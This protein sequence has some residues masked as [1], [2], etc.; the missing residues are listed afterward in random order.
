MSAN[1]KR[2]NNDEPIVVESVNT[3]KTDRRKLK[4]VEKDW[5]TATCYD[6]DIPRTNTAE[7]AA[8][9]NAS[10]FIKQ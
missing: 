10:R 3:D 1:R 9:S 6:D 8:Y 4:V 7:F 2:Q 5:Y